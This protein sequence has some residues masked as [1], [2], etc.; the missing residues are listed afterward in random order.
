MIVQTEIIEKRKSETF[1]VYAFVFWGMM[2][3]FYH[4]QYL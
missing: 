4:F 1:L 3:F 2:S